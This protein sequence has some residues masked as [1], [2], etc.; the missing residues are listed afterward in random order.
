MENNDLQPFQTVEPDDENARPTF[1]ESLRLPAYFTLF[2]WFI[3]VSKRAIGLDFYWWGIYPREG[4]GLRGI[5]FAPLL[6]ENWE[7]LA[8]N[9]VPFL[10]SSVIVVYFFPRVALRAFW[11]IYFISGL[12]VWIFARTEAFVIGLSYVVYGLVSFI[13]F[14]GIFRRSVRSI[15]LALIIV[16]LYSGMFE[17]VLPTPEI[18]KKHISWEA[19]LIGAIV[20]ALMAYFYKHELEEDEIHHPSVSDADKRP[21][22]DADTFDKTREQ[23]RREYEEHLADLRREQEERWRQQNLPPFGGWVS[24][25][26][27]R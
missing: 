17:G 21:F 25:D 16:T 3:H 4:I 11:L 6:H 5:F 20:G 19:H 18:L 14:S 12:C 22:F 1:L 26:T 7:H 23:R 27:F 2:I 9:T 24:D 8:S 15:V 13:L 10:V